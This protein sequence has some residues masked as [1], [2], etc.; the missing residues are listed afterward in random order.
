MRSRLFMGTLV[1]ALALAALPSFAFATEDPKVAARALARKGYELYD[2]ESYEQAIQA[3]QDAEQLYHAPTLVFMLGKAHVKIG[4]LLEARALF[5]KVADEKLAP[6]ASADFRKAQASARQEL[7]ALE[8]LIPTLRIIITGAAGRALTVKLDGLLLPSTDLDRP[9]EQNPGSHA[10]SVLPEGSPEVAR[11]V[12]L[13]QSEASELRI[14]L[15]PPVVAQA[16][17]ATRTPAPRDRSSRVPAYVSFGAGALGLGVGIGLGLSTL[18]KASDIKAHCT[19]QGLCPSSQRDATAAANT[20]S[21]G[22]TAGFVV[23]GVGAALGVTFLLRASPKA[24]A[25]A[26]IVI[27]PLSL[28]AEGVF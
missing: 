6:S 5:N 26:G 27:G 9:L 8:P 25:R 4:K 16:S 3:L 22:S 28:G 2:A 18:N 17:N 12:I 24:P 20:L 21:A 11:S 14:Q 15:P 10:V 19:P 23:A 1:A 13:K 7:A